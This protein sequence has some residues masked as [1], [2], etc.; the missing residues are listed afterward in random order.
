MD[1]D[2]IRVSDKLCAF[3]YAADI[4]FSA[5]L[6]SAFT[7]LIFNALLCVFP[8]HILGYI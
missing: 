2:S 5:M 8:P 7:M 1:T 6:A 3:V 4:F